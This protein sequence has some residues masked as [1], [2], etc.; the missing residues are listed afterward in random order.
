VSA[1]ETRSKPCFVL[2]EQPVVSVSDQSDADPRCINA[3][4]AILPAAFD[5]SPTTAIKRG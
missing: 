5:C 3:I 1:V 4:P 2:P